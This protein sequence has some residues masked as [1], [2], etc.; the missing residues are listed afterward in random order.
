[1]TGKKKKR[2]V[3]S[4]L[5]CV[6]VEDDSP[7][8]STCQVSG[9]YF[10]TSPRLPLWASSLIFSHEKGFSNENTLLSQQKCA[11][12]T[13]IIYMQVHCMNYTKNYKLLKVWFGLFVVL[14]HTQRYF[15]YISRCS[16]WRNVAKLF[17]LNL[18]IHLLVRYEE[19]LNLSNQTW[20][21][22]FN[23]MCLW[24][25]DALRDNKVHKRAN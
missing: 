22:K 6:L 16:W 10:L 4:R 15:S 21:R 11:L 25:T 3:D 24:N 9:A 17:L 5:P 1:M 8:K 23:K 14:R 13:V 2:Y 19:V 18:R 7:Y 20:K 12:S